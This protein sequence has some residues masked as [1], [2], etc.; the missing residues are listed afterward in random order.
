MKD[1]PYGEGF[2]DKEEMPENESVSGSCLAGS[3]H[4]DLR[5]MVQKALK[6]L[7]KAG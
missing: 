5:H 7:E 4:D 2:D 3:N 1:K 6:K